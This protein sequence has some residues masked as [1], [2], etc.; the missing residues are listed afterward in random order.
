ME[1]EIEQ[2]YT[3]EDIAYTIALL[4]KHVIKLSK[5]D[6]TGDDKERLEQLAY[7]LL[8]AKNVVE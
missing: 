6:Y 1:D 3:F 4:R 7:E 5:T 2:L 8:K